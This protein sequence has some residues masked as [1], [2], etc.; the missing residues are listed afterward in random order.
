MRFR[1]LGSRVSGLWL[2][3]FRVGAVGSQIPHDHLLPE[4]GT[5]SGGPSE[6]GITKGSIRATIRDLK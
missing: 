1:V 3:R 2:G 5:Y 6:Q 4:V